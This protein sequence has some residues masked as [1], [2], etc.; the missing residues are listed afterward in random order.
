MDGQRVRKLLFLA[1]FLALFLLVAR[2]FYPF[3]TVIL[4]SALIYAF[5]E[6]L[7]RKVSRRRDGSERKPLVN[8]I[9]AGIFSIGGV[10]VLVIPVLFL[11]L[12]LVRQAGELASS[13][14]ATLDGNPAFLDLSPDGMLGGLVHRLSEGRVDLS[15]FDFKGEIRDFIAGK[16]GAIIGFSGIVL[17]DALGFVITLAF[18]VFT[19]YFFFVDGRHLVEI[20]IRAVPIETSYTTLFL[21]KLKETGR[22]LVLGFF[23]VA[24]MQAAMMLALCLAFGISGPLVLAALTAV[25]SFVPM[26]GT[27][28][29]WA[30]VAATL[31]L[32]G[33]IGLG[34]AFAVL[35]AILVST[36][37]NFIR[38]VLLHDRLK[39][40]PLLIFF[41]IIGG[42]SLFGFNG[43]LL[44]PLILMLFFSAAELFDKVYARERK[45]RKPE[46]ERAESGRE[47]QDTREE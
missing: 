18:M 9:I 21:H 24:L 44:G 26:V 33:K 31:A 7:H 38:P 5:L 36:L 12:A 3:L 40:H 34:I 32:S 25:A 19:L 17:K 6:P 28:L 35:A 14:V 27:S 39:I 46:P 43:L 2:L 13:I 42:L 20:L 8:T 15:A 47:R 4:W 41:A 1:L 10:C 23:L 45:Q 11:G 22:Q 37:D 16:S 30:P 29:V